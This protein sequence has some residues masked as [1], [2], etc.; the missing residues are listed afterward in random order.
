MLFRRRE[1]KPRKRRV[2]KLRL[3]A[4]ASVLGLVC[5]VSFVY[6]LVTA[7]ASEIPRLDP[8]NE[9]ELQEDGYVYASDGK[10]VLAVLRGRES[11]IVVDSEEIAPVVKQA[12]VAV[13]DRRYW[14]HRGVD[15][16]GIARAV[17]ADL[18]EKEAVQG[19]S[20]IT[21]QFV[22][23]QYRWSD[24]T[25]SRKLKE[26]ALAWQLE[27]RW[28]K[29]RILTAYLNTVFFGNGAYGIEMAAQVYFRKHARDLDLAEAALLAGIPANPVAYD[30]VANRRA[31]RARRQT[32]LQL[33]LAQ[34]LITERDLERASRRR[35]PRP[36]EVRLPRT[37]GPAQHFVEYVKQQLI[38][39][40]GSGELF[41]GGLRV[42]TSIDLEL[43]KRA[44]H[45]VEKWLGPLHG[46]SAALVAIDPRDG[47]VL[48]MYG[49]G[50]FR[51]SQF[52]L[53]V[54]GERQPGS[55]FK[56]FVLATALGMGISPE[57]TFESKPT[58]IN[59]G[60]KL[61]SV[62]N[63]EG[64]YLGTIDLVDATTYSDNAVYAQLTALVGPG[65]IRRMAHELGIASP[66]DDYFAIGL[67]AEAVNPLEMAR[68]F[69][70]FANGGARVDGEVLGNRPRAVLRVVDGDRVEKNA[71]VKEQ[72]LDPNEAAT[73]NAI[74][75]T[76]VEEGTGER[77][78][79]ADR[80]AAGKTGTT[81]NY[82]DAWFVGYT[83]QLAVAVWVGYPNKLLPMLT[84]FH[85]APVAG[86]T[87][88]ALIWKT[89]MQEALRY[90][91]EPSEY[92]PAPEYRSAVP[93]RVV[94]RN[95][96]WL[97]DNGNCRDAHELL[98]ASGFEPEKQASCK[99]NEVDVPRVIGATV[100]EA[101]ERLARQPLAADVVSRPAEPGERVGIVVDQYP[102]S[103]TLSSWDTVRLVTTKAIDGVV[104]RLVGLP[105]ERAQA[106]LA[107]R[108]LIPIVE[109][110]ADG[111]ARIV[112]A[113]SPRGG[114]AAAPNRL[115]KLRVGRR[116]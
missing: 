9:A 62:E 55:A 28:S 83:P 86:G 81:E 50:S 115:V 15:V 63:Y 31:A 107:R 108:G 99:P 92:F 101:E 13:E 29:D 22:K 57:T 111:N 87:Y 105:L 44:R 23:N 7:I 116:G 49:G 112:L 37:R 48:A 19:G 52:N 10:T 24:R 85:G 109:S 65:N 67:G 42:T 6:G 3:L 74:L 54:Q 103:G 39:H 16:R 91:D 2:R 4:L 46:P 88:P 51:E 100:A 79:L 12:I 58:V 14:E 82:G 17:W 68:A 5:A 75:E 69:S 53:A 43:Q 98:Y 59:L 38:S 66:L 80:P 45:A 40:Y 78:A 97:R 21:Q 35:L 61:W 93:V 89:F 56:P 114:L 26:A 11:R 77:A 70:T 25:I 30:P 1:R 20:T 41:G 27:R 32:V 76:V 18:R 102:R 72:I 104:P 60:D 96:E 64:S 94:R 110:L 34:G 90:L 113:Q 8:R 47:R 106:L 73:M 71:P 33:M 36:Q 84:E 95:G